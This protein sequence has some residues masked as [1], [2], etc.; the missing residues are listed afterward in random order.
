MSATYLCKQLCGELIQTAD[1]CCDNKSQFVM[2]P[3]QIFRIIKFSNKICLK[4]GIVVSTCWIESKSIH[5]FELLR[6][7]NMKSSSTLMP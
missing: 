1:F 2:P 5:F 7:I 4:N 6:E 3:Q